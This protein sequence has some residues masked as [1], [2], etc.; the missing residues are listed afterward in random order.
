MLAGEESLGARE[1]ERA[2]A[3]F[4]DEANRDRRFRFFSAYKHR[5]VC[6]ALAAAFHGKCAYCESYYAATQGDEVD[7]YRPKGRIRT[8]TGTERPGYYWLASTWDNLLPSCSDCNRWRWKDD[9]EGARMLSGKAEWF[10]L[11]DE[12]ARA[13]RP[14]DEVHEDALLL[15]PYY[16]D[17]D[18]HLEFVDEGVVRSAPGRD[19][20]PSARGE[21]TIRVHGLRRHGLVTHRRTHLERVLKQLRGVL[22]AE[23]RAAENLDDEALRMELEAQLTE[24]RRFVDPTTPY[25]TMARQVIARWR[26]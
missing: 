19:G 23:R 11:A 25:S 7:H 26:P 18:E 17:P 15:H 6:H 3:F 4:A 9:H 1:R 2:I 8:P 20:R 10:P 16:D 24:L 22:T 13:R 21:E 5:D 12:A 14:G